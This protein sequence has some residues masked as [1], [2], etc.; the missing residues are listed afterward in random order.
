MLAVEVLVW[1]SPT[2]HRDE[3]GLYLYADSRN[4]IKIMVEGARRHYQRPEV[5]MGVQIDARPQSCPTYWS[6][7]GVRKGSPF[8]LR[9][10]VDPA[11]HRC[12]G[13]V[14]SD[15][16]AR[17]HV[18]GVIALQ[19]PVVKEQG[20]FGGGGGGGSAAAELSAAA[21]VAACE[22]KP[23]RL[24]LLSLRP[25]LMTSTTKV[26]TGT[27][28]VQLSA[29]FADFEAVLETKGSRSVQVGSEWLRIR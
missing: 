18:V 7:K 16:D 21:R 10:E 27:A 19:G 29:D 5:S 24:D 4:Y 22:K 25:M 11:T 17:W 13:M 2:A 14:W 9:L 26:N 3:A 20:A 15:V 28:K 8:R 1:F 23:P 12:A 6:G